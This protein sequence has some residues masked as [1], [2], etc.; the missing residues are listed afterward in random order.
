[1]DEGAA[2][3]AGDE[4]PDADATANGR[5]SVVFCNDAVGGGSFSA[6]ADQVPK[7]LR[8]AEKLN[9]MGNLR[10]IIRDVEGCYP[11]MPKPAIREALTP[12]PG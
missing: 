1:M 11:N 10:C 4:A 5:S 6:K 9:Q 2:D 7:F 12:F 3:R 8:E